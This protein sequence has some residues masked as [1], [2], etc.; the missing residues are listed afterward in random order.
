VVLAPQVVPV[1]MG[2][3]NESLHGRYVRAHKRRMSIPIPVPGEISL[4]S[5]R[6]R[7]AGETREDIRGKGKLGL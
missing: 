6:R 5:W 3:P 2:R 7:K 1:D 4:V